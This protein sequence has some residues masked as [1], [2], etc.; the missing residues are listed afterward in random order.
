MNL[1]SSNSM[2]NKILFRITITLISIHIVLAAQY[3]FFNLD[4]FPTKIKSFYK[5]L[6]ILGPF[7]SDD[8]IAV[9]PHLFVSYPS[10]SGVWSPFRDMAQENFNTF[11]QHPWRYDKLKWSDYERYVMRKANP[12]V[13]S[14]TEIDGS[15]GAASL[16]LIQYLNVLHPNKPDSIM[17]LCVWNTWQPAIKS[18]KSDT[19]FF[20]VYKLKNGGSAK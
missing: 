16:E 12:E 20:V 11:Q 7:F 13:N 18:V 5:K 1:H 19:A 14:S 8:R 17:L 9:S 6:V 10:A 2:L 4:I 15:E 3:I